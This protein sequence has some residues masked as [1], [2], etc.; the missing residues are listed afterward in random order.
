METVKTE[1][2]GWLSLSNA[3]EYL[4]ISKRSLKKAVYL[5]LNGVANSAL[6]IK[7]IGNRLYIKIDSLDSIS[8]IE[9]IQKGQN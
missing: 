9:T 5:K 8:N 3:A 7:K 1:D 4:D 6:V 2:K